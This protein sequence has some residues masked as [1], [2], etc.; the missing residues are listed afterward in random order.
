MQDLW[1]HCDDLSVTKR[2][3]GEIAALLQESAHLPGNT[4]K[5]DAQLQFSIAVDLNETNAGGCERP[6]LRGS[7]F[8]H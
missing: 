3:E 8:V 6:L 4:E 1:A 7:F 5:N 2:N